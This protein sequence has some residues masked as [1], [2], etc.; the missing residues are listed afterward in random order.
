MFLIN[1]NR[2]LVSVSRSD[3]IPKDNFI[4]RVMKTHICSNTQSFQ[5]HAAEQVLYCSKM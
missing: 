5:M 2:G 4:E 1:F 3:L